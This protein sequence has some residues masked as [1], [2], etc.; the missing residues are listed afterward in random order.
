MGRI[1][2]ALLFY[3]VLSQNV[4]AKRRKKR[5]AEK[6]ISKHMDVV[7]WPKKAIACKCFYRNINM[8]MSARAFMRVPW[9]KD[10]DSFQQNAVCSVGQMKNCEYWAANKTYIAAK[11]E[12]DI[13]CME[14]KA[15]LQSMFCRDRD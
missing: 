3:S 14:R 9:E 13:A 2:D 6:A 5:V 10:C 15:F 1:L 4:R 7:E 12:Y 11:Q 8:P